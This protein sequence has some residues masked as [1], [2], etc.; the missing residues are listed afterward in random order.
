MSEGAS[1]CIYDLAYI[2]SP[3]SVS[4]DTPHYLAA[5]A[6]IHSQRVVPFA[7]VSPYVAFAREVAS[8]AC[9]PSCELRSYAEM[10]MHSLARDHSNIHSRECTVA[11]SSNARFSQYLA[12]QTRNL[13]DVSNE[14]KERFSISH[15]NPDF[16]LFISDSSIYTRI[17]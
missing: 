4:S 9:G 15:A 3:F 13:S 1:L 6:F 17:S 14:S 12:E 10:I 8:A 7:L 11:D 2:F 16:V 5:T